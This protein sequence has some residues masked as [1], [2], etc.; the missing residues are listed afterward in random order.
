MRKYFEYLDKAVEH[1]CDWKD[2]T[3]DSE[4]ARIVLNGLPSD[5]RR[6]FAEPQRMLINA[7]VSSFIPTPC[8]F[9]S[10]HLFIASLPI[11]PTL[12]E[13]SPFS[14]KSTIATQASHV[15]SIIPPRLLQFHSRPCVSLRQGHNVW[16]LKINERA[17][18]SFS[19][20][21]PLDLDVTDAFCL[22]V[23]CMARRNKGPV[24]M[25][26]SN[27]VRLLHRTLVSF[28]SWCT[29]QR[30]HALSPKYIPRK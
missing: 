23:E 28:V 19:V 24:K 5:L 25:N 14:T 29:A 27:K 9:D 2:K 3:K 16:P 11:A 8:A 30:L 4:C 21:S 17:L 26:L 22:Q 7:V 1:K 18:V 10:P 12:L 15:W 20:F 6:N 13:W